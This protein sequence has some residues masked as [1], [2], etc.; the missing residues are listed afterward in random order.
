[1]SEKRKTRKRSKIK[2]WLRSWVFTPLGNVRIKLINKVERQRRNISDGELNQIVPRA[3]TDRCPCRF[4]RDRNDRGSIPVRRSLLENEFES[5]VD[6]VG[7]MSARSENARQQ[8]SRLDSCAAN[9]FVVDG[10]PAVAATKPKSPHDPRGSW[11][12]DEHSV[13]RIMNPDVSWLNSEDEKSE[14]SGS[15][16][17]IEDRNSLGGKSPDL[18][19][20]LSG[21][22]RSVLVVEPVQMASP[23]VIEELA[24][25]LSDLYF[26]HQPDP[27]LCCLINSALR[28]SSSPVVFDNGICLCDHSSHGTQPV[29]L[30]LPPSDIPP[31]SVRRAKS[32]TNTMEFLIRQTQRRRSTILN[33]AYISPY[34]PLQP[35][36]LQIRKASNATSINTQ[37][38]ALSPIPTEPSHDVTAPVHSPSYSLHCKIQHGPLPPL[39]PSRPN[40][41]STHSFS[42]GPAGP[43]SRPPDISTIIPSA[44]ALASPIDLPQ[45]PDRPTSMCDGCLAMRHRSLQSHPSH[46]RGDISPQFGNPPLPY[47]LSPQEPTRFPPRVDSLPA[48]LRA[49]QQ[50]RHCP[51]RRSGIVSPPVLVGPRPR[52]QVFNRLSASFSDSAPDSPWAGP[53][54]PTGFYAMSEDELPSDGESDRIESIDSSGL[55]MCLIA[56]SRAQSRRYR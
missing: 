27:P 38:D 45:Y 6:L 19:S 30:H 17:V 10:V 33:N 9:G 54:G 36:P 16:S 37:N 53:V 40:T 14:K 41:S 1:M 34:V 11:R 25:Q 39:P 35:R 13:L 4:F 8:F 7:P 12:E 26:I 29:I 52:A 2:R 18:P 44:S 21:K 50:C 15:M 24:P 49:G 43:S 22:S 31:S 20:E 51:T 32:P 48:S 23:L 55:E 28:D 46:C 42:F 47:P 3:L 56:G 5:L